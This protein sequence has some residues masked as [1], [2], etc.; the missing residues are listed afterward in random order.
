MAKEPCLPVS[1]FLLYLKLAPI[2]K[3]QKKE[4]KKGKE[5]EGRRG[6]REGGT[7]KRLSIKGCAFENMLWNTFSCH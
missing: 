2:M 6:G 4:R 7:E 3:E 1:C 5:G